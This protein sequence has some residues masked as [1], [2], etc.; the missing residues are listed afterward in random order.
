M[1]AD[2]RSQEGWRPD[3][4]GP[5]RGCTTHQHSLPQARP[6][7]MAS[8]VEHKGLSIRGIVRATV[9]F[10]LQFHHLSSFT[11]WQVCPQ[12]TCSLIPSRY[13]QII[14]PLIRIVERPLASRRAL[15]NNIN[16][17]MSLRFV[18][19]SYSDPKCVALPK[20]LH[21]TVRYLPSL[22]RLC[23]LSKP[24]DLPNIRPVS[25]KLLAL[26]KTARD[27]LHVI[28][29]RHAKTLTNKCTTNKRYAQNQYQHRPNDCVISKTI[30]VFL[31][32]DHLA[33]R[34]L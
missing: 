12:Y 1:E 19:Y 26:P 13:E 6:P 32:L 21:N 22:D 27:E 3:P 28:P 8:S 34:L 25:S 24:S 15:S 33:D 23:Q 16:T 29:C 30:H 31:L 10:D 11:F 2:R 5:P 14:D 4:S 17:N 20:H 7:P 9:Y 18:D